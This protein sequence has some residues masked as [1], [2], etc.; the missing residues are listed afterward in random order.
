M[1]KLIYTLSF[2][3]FAC[4]SANDKPMILKNDCGLH[5]C[6]TVRKPGSLYCKK[7]SKEIGERENR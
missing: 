1:K 4:Q 6:N 3:L 7:H 5:G 2:L